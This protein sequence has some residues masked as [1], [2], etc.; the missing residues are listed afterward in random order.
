MLRR[1]STLSTRRLA[2]MKGPEDRHSDRQVQRL[3]RFLLLS[4]EEH[5]K[6]SAPPSPAG[7]EDPGGAG[8]V[9]RVRG[10]VRAPAYP[11]ISGGLLGAGAI[12]ETLRL[13]FGSTVAVAVVITVAAVA[14]AL[15]ATLP[16][17]WR[18]RCPAL[19]GYLVVLA[20]PLNFLFRPAL[21]LTVCIGGL[22]GFYT[23]ARH[24]VHHPVALAAFGITLTVVVDLLHVTTDVFDGP[25]ADPLPLGSRGSLGYFAESFLIGL[26]ILAAVSAGDAVRSR[27]G[28]R[29]ERAAAQAELIRLERHKAAEAERRAIARELHDIVSH[30]VSV[31][32]VQAESATYTTPGLSPEGRDGFQQIAG[33]SREALNELRQLLNVLRS[34]EVAGRR[35]AAEA[36]QPTLDRL[37]EL[38]AQHRNGGGSARLTVTGA[39]RRLPASIE[40]TAYRIV[41]E[42]LTNVR[43]H[44]PGAAAEI[45]LEYGANRL[46]VRVGDAGP[47]PP[48]GIS[49]PVRGHGLIGMTER[50]TLAG[51][52]LTTGRGP[53]DGFLVHAELPV[54]ADG[55]GELW[56]MN[57]GGSG[58][59]IGAMAAIRGRGREL[60]VGS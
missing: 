8:F 35:G 54:V 47:G 27:E 14:T 46:A 21:F 26:A 15:A 31:I 33:A 4:P 6:R 52:R 34:D 58:E 24:R 23:L 44:A 51:G 37:D 38:L 48:A 49:A 39:R 30:S 60:G 18:R 57:S 1:L 25:Y 20:S 56:S 16:L 55:R 41:Q 5:G 22:L 53:A 36:P 12:A 59:G 40:L 2:G 45:A 50:V 9:Q 3:A 28:V 32:A 17:M 13:D 42:A 7:A 10:W 19:A 11:W 29:R 43:R